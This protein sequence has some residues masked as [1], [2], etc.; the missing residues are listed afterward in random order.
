M[1]GQQQEPTRSRALV[2]ATTIIA[3]VVAVVALAALAPV[4]ASA[5]TTVSVTMTFT[6]PT[7][8]SINCPGFPDVSCGRGEVIPIGQASETVVFGA[9]CGGSC[10]RRTISLAGGS[11][12]FDETASG[13]TCPGGMCRPGPLELGSATLT[14]VAVG[15]TGTYAR[16]TGTFTGTVRAE[17]S[18]ARPAGTAT[19]KLS[20]AISCGG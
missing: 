3:A 15:G 20:G 13:G 16:A 19:V 11:L 18:N 1:S 12:I 14:D 2:G 9:G 7:H 10:D 5:A 8:P 4:A 6:E 17:V